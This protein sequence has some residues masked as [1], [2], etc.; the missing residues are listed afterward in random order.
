MQGESKCPIHPLLDVMHNSSTQQW[1]LWTTGWRTGLHGRQRVQTIAINQNEGSH[2]N[3]VQGK[4]PGS[5]RLPITE[6]WDVFW[7]WG[8]GGMWLSRRKVQG[9][10]NIN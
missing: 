3:P 9:T 6:P 4:V 1:L 8:M 2:R 10:H 5:M 7:E